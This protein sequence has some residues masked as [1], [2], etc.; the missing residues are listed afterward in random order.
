LL[1]LAVVLEI[2]EGVWV[3]VVV[4]VEVVVERAACHFSK[5]R[6]RSL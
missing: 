1:S 2:R 6:R 5:G 4:V 3:V